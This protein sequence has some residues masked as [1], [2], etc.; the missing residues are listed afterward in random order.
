MDVDKEFM[1]RLSVL[2]LTEKESKLYYYLLKYGPKTPTKAAKS[3][4]TYREDTHRTLTALVDKGM[5]SVSLQRHTTYSAVP[6]DVALESLRLG[7]LHEQQRIQ[8]AEQTLLTLSRDLTPNF[9]EDSDNFKMLKD[10][11]KIIAESKQTILRAEHDLVFIPPDKLGSER[12]FGVID[13]YIEAKRRGVNIRAVLDIVPY[14]VPA[15]RELIAHG[16]Q[17]RHYPSY[18]GVRFLVIDGRE[19]L[20]SISLDKPRPFVESVA[21]FWCNSPTYARHLKTLF[22]FVWSQSVDAA[23]RIAELSALDYTE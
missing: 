10:P 15:T 13:A 7:R 5:A 21:A 6:L 22:E 11:L 20:T 17:L 8:E 4:G 3:L 2:E 18:R 23:E 16:I 9:P 14:V 1:D 12:R 19:S